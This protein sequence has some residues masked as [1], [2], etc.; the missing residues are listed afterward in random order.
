MNIVTS[1]HSIVVTL[2]VRNLLD[3]LAQATANHGSGHL[4]RSTPAG[5][6]RVIAEQDAQHYADRTPGYGSG[7]VR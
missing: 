6:L 1:E 7:L 5:I 2:S 4:I 3:L